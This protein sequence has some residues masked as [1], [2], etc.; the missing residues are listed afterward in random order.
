LADVEEICDRIGILHYGELYYE[1]TV[2]K[3]IKDA[4]TKNLEQAFLDAI[5]KTNK[6]KASKQKS[7]KNKRAA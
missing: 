3:F 7:P 2:A 5:N 6:Q 4:K 1:G